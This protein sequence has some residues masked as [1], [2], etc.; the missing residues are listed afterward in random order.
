MIFFQKSAFSNFSQ[1]SSNKWCSF[2]TFLLPQKGS[3]YMQT[4]SK[5]T[6]KLGPPL[7]IIHGFKSSRKSKYIHGFGRIPGVNQQRHDS[8]WLKHAILGRLLIRYQ[9]QA[10]FQFLCPFFGTRL[11]FANKRKTDFGSRVSLYYF[12]G[13]A[14]TDAFSAFTSLSW[15]SYFSSLYDLK[16]LGNLK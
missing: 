12:Q 1:F 5:M 7:F 6:G 16:K 4:E 8:Q 14:S 13:G 11:F 15:S 3:G 10:I 9:E 2:L